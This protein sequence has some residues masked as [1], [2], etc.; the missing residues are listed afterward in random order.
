MDDASWTGLEKGLHGSSLDRF[1]HLSRACLVKSE[2]YFDAFDRVP[3]SRSSKGVEGELEIETEVLDWLKDPK[4]FEPLTEEQRAACS[5][6]SPR[7]ELL[8]KFL[9]TLERA[10]RTPRR[11]R[12]VGRHRWA[13]ALRPRRRAPDRD[14]RRRPGPRNRSAMK[15]AEERRFKDYRTD[16][17]LDLRQT[18]VALTRLR[19]LTRTGRGD[20]LDLD[21]TIDETCRRPARSSSC[22]AP[23]ARTTCACSC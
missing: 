23:S 18:K 22:S 4:N 5:S 6:A 20:E 1:Y 16:E 13:L 15:V 2:T 19:Q 10:D 14:P 11:R 17:T 7:D 9:E 21:E 3:S 12:E 8:Q